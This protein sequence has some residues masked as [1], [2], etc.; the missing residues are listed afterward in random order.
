[1]V[2]GLLGWNVNEIRCFRPLEG[3]LLGL[4]PW[5]TAVEEQYHAW[6]NWLGLPGAIAVI[7]GLLGTV[8][9]IYD[10]YSEEAYYWMLAILALLFAINGLWVILLLRVRLC[11]NPLRSRL[12]YYLITVVSL[13]SGNL[14]AIAL[15][16]ISQV[17]SNIV[18][19]VGIHV[20]VFGQVSVIVQLFNISF[21]A[22]YAYD[23]RVRGLVLQGISDYVGMAVGLYGVFVGALLLVPMWHFTQRRAT[24]ATVVLHPKTSECVLGVQSDVK[25]GDDND[26]ALASLSFDTDLLENARGTV[27]EGGD[28]RMMGTNRDDANQSALRDPWFSCQLKMCGAKVA[29]LLSQLFRRS[30]EAQQFVIG[31]AVLPCD[32]CAEIFC[33]SAPAPNVLG[34]IV[35]PMSATILPGQVSHG[36]PIGQLPPVPHDSALASAVHASESVNNQRSFGSTFVG[37]PAGG[38]L[39]ADGG[40]LGRES[41]SEDEFQEVSEH[42]RPT[43]HSMLAHCRRCQLQWLVLEP[44]ADCCALCGTEVSDGPL[45]PESSDSQEVEDRHWVPCAELIVSG[46][47][48]EHGPDVEHGPHAGPGVAAVVG[49]M[50]LPGSTTA[51]DWPLNVEP[52]GDHI[53]LER[54][55]VA[56]AGFGHGRRCFGSLIYG[57][58]ATAAEVSDICHDGPSAGPTTTAPDVASVGGGAADVADFVSVGGDI[59][60]VASM[61]DE[62]ADVA[63]VGGSSAAMAPI[64]GH[65]ALEALSMVYLPSE[66]ASSASISDASSTCTSV[67]EEEGVG[68]ERACPCDAVLL[69]DALYCHMCGA[70]APAEHEAAAIAASSHDPGSRVA[71]RGS[72]VASQVSC[73]SQ[74]SE[75]LLR[76]N[77]EAYMIRRMRQEVTASMWNTGLLLHGLRGPGR[78]SALEVLP[79][80]AFDAIAQSLDPRFQS[81]TLFDRIKRS[82]TDHAGGGRGARHAMAGVGGDA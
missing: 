65:V 59:A 11:K 48:R 30:S 52:N 68:C 74:F 10:K 42:R 43:Q 17:V 3:R 70:R 14:V 46:S 28:D 34:S 57:M 20:F 18:L 16:S 73:A 4:R 26:G 56:K 80:E 61:G 33:G 31:D 47:E 55:S 40:D 53:D 37:L 21:V 38:S 12:Y 77:A 60:D 1:M 64:L 63:S 58:E 71:S 19:M 24:A 27:P 49:D 67:E 35:V 41:I 6:R 51:V 76:T 39:H 50:R 62:V 45:T 36:T 7:P 66:S 69:P 79:R 2:F 72:S 75:L 54:A 78:P 13:S 81:Y 23:V 15:P 5:P 8:A 32:G 44:Q 29:R 9:G 25:G 22:F 82:L